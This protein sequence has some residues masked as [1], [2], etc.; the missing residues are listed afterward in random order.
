MKPYI[1]CII[2]KAL[3][4]MNFINTIAWV[5]HT[6][7]LLCFAVAAHST[8]QLSN[9]KIIPDSQ[10]VVDFIEETVGLS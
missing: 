8:D 1:G 9:C 6:S 2:A 3:K 4:K 10:K 5:F 7:L